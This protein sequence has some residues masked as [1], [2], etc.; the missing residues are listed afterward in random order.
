[1]SEIKVNWLKFR[2]LV[3]LAVQ[4]KNVNPY[5]GAIYTRGEQEFSNII[6]SAA[7]HPSKPSFS[8][9]GCLVKGSTFCQ[10]VQSATVAIGQAEI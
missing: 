1:M 7:T 8:S 6:P 5:I 2:N 10:P 3:S 9:P 4:E